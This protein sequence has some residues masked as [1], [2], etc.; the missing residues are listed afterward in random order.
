MAKKTETR[1]RRTG[2]IIIAPRTKKVTGCAELR[3][4]VSAMNACSET[5]LDRYTTDELLQ[6]FRMQLRSEWDFYPDG[7]E[8]RQIREALGGRVPTWNNDESPSYEEGS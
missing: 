7:W 3:L 6:L 5:F 8:D 4:I 1:L 2:D